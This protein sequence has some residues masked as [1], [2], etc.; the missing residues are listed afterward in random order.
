MVTRRTTSQNLIWIAG[1]TLIS[2]DLL[3]S[4]HEL[5]DLACLFAGVPGAFVKHAPMLLPTVLPLV[6]QGLQTL[7]Y[8]HPMLSSCPLEMLISF[9]SLLRVT[10]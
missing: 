6:W 5:A 7:V 9:C 1:A 10:C 8:G 3:P 4:F 2:S